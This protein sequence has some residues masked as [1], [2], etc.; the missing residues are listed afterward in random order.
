VR[1]QVGRRQ[2]HSFVE[3][4]ERNRDGIAEAAARLLARLQLSISHSRR[5]K[6]VRRSGSLVND[7]KNAG[8]ENDEL[9]NSK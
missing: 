3:A 7:E 6:H 2:F 1:D 8:L 9:E 4:G 5:S